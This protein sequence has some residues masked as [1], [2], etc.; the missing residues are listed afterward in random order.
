MLP[1]HKEMIKTGSIFTNEKKFHPCKEI[2]FE[3][4]FHPG[5]LLRI[6]PW[7]YITR[8]KSVFRIVPDPVT[9]HVSWRTKCKDAAFLPDG[10][11]FHL[12]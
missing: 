1:L 3:I 4:I 12:T 9:V 11:T 6:A 2:K 8:H 7:L 5:F 10:L